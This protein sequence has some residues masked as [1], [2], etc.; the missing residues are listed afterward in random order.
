MALPENNDFLKFSSG[1][2]RSIEKNY[3]NLEYFLMR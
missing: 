1:W 2:H 3:L